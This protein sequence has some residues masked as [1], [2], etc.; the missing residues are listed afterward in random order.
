MNRQPPLHL[1][2]DLRF[3]SPLLKTAGICAQAARDVFRGDVYVSQ[4]HFNAACFYMEDTYLRV[5]VLMWLQT[6]YHGDGVSLRWTSP[7]IVHLRVVSDEYHA[8]L[9][10]YLKKGL[11]PPE[12][13]VHPEVLEPELLLNVVREYPA[14]LWS[15]ECADWLSPIVWESPSPWS[16]FILGP[17]SLIRRSFKLNPEGALLQCIRLVPG[18][19]PLLL[20]K[21]TQEQLYSVDAQGSS[22]LELSVGNPKAFILLARHGAP[23]DGAQRAVVNALAQGIVTAQEGRSMRRALHRHEGGQ[24]TT[25]CRCC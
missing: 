16:V 14:I 17:P 19:L 25:R 15:R 11:P 20:R 5:L 2:R 21:V 22:L 24:S 4:E 9:I 12:P 7:L 6:W 3:M 10:H 1:S 18:N 13:L 8:V 23:T